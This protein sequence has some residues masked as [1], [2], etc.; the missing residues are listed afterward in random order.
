MFDKMLST[1]YRPE[2]NHY[3]GNYDYTQGPSFPVSQISRTGEGEQGGVGSNTSERRE[4]QLQTV[5]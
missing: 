2:A 1:K 4:R 5:V 3:M